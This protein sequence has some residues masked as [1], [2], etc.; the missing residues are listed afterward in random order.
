VLD[1]VSLDT[2]GVALDAG[3]LASE[4]VE[5]LSGAAKASPAARLGFHL[6]P[7]TAFARAGAAPGPIDGHMAA[8]AEA[9]AN[10]CRI[11][12]RASLFLASGQALHEAGGGEAGEIA[13][14]AACAL[15]YARALDDAGLPPAE[16]LTRIVLGL[17][18]DTDP[19]LSIA[20]LRAARMV[21]R[22]IAV[23]CGAEAAARIEARTSERML[24]AADPW[25]NLVRIATAGFSAAVGGADTVVPAAFTD[26]IGLPAALARRLARNTALIIAEE[27]RLCAVADP[28][29][30]S[31]T[32]EALS[33]DLARAAWERLQAIETAGGAAAALSAGLIARWA[34]EGAKALEGEIAC[35]QRKIVGV[36]DWRPEHGDPVEVEPAPTAGQRPPPPGLPGPASHCPALAP[37]RLEALAR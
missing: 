19:L 2:A 25:T 15:A 1:G 8:S 23:A 13:L 36:T 35:G 26:A 34:G 14:A 4:S 32:F 29:G 12:P 27:A 16:A 28:A 10:L 3:F 9:G 37:I 17:A 20:K 33:A 11:H 5:W 7:L 30:G 22:R 31:W 24:T 21:W 18:V 6:D